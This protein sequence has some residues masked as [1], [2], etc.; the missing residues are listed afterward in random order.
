MVLR[1]GKLFA[2]V[3]KMK[4]LKINI[5]SL[6]KNSWKDAGNFTVTI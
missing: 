6:I 3:I 5:M 2:V 4:K 1:L